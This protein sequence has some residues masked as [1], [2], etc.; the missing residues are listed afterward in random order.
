MAPMDNENRNA[1]ASLILPAPLIRLDHAYYLGLMQRVLALAKRPWFEA[2][3][4]WAKLGAELD[5]G[6]WYTLYSRTVLVAFPKFAEQAETHRAELDLAWLATTIERIKRE[7]GE[8]PLDLSAL[9][10]PSE[11]G[12][13][14]PFTGEPYH[15]ER[16]AEGYLLSSAKSEHLETDEAAVLQIGRDS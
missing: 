3:D 12:I 10:A 4:E 15:Y 16:T 13:I 7:S 9:A 14:D 8:F 5:D 1:L 2:E 11:R 6:P